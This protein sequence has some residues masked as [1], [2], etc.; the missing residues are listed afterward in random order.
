[1]RYTSHLWSKEPGNNLPSNTSFSPYSQFTGKSR[2]GLGVKDSR[3]CSPAVWFGLIY[4][5]YCHIHTSR[6]APTEWF[7][8]FLPTRVK[9]IKW[10]PIYKVL[11]PMQNTW[12]TV[13]LS[14]MF[15]QIFLEYNIL[16]IMLFQCWH[17]TCI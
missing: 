1:M 14:L 15:S 17:S 6:M 16:F 12:C 7:L 4:G 2:M 9:K 8:F 3:F 13:W 11:S 5:L 10:Y